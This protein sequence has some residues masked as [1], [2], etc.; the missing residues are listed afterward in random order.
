VVD[1]NPPAIRPG[2]RGEC[3]NGQGSLIEGGK[4]RKVKTKKKGEVE[5]YITF[6]TPHGTLLGQW[7]KRGKKVF[8]NKRDLNKER[9]KSGQSK[10]GGKTG[11]L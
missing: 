11:Q 7:T 3:Q 4:E 8:Q 5:E 9:K 6:L 10:E 2:S 1:E